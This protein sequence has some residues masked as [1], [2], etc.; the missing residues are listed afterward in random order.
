MTSPPAYLTEYLNKLAKDEGFVEHTLHYE[1]GSNHGDGF[2][3]VM[4]AVTIKGKKTVDADGEDELSLM[5]K[6]LPENRARR[7]FF[8]SYMLFEREVCVY[9]RFLPMFEKFQN[10]RNISR[11]DGFFQYPKCYLAVANAAD[12]HY[13]IVMENVKVSNYEL[14]DK[15]KPVDFD[16]SSIFLQTLGRYHAI[17]IALRDQKPELFKE[18][19][20]LEDILT[21]MVELPNITNMMHGAMDKAIEHLTCEDEKNI[22]RKLRDD[23]KQSIQNLFAPGAAGH[24]GVLLHGDCWNNNFCF[25]TDANN[26]PSE[27]CLFDWQVSCVGSPVLDL[28]YYLL[29]STTKEL[30]VRYTDLIEVYHNSISELLTKLGSDPIK[31]CPIDELNRQLKQFGVYGVIMAPILLQ[32]IVS[33]SKNIVDMDSVTADTDNIDMATMDDKS[34]IVYRDRISDAL[35]DA[36]KFGWI[37]L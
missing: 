2:V 34:K 29:T 3:A 12:D 1:S 4:V 8:N 18:L 9:S 7:E 11:S 37:N 15:M 30:R 21:A 27:I 22:L 13:V 36:I 17:S 6:L 31:L 10:D 28:S 19:L 32:V 33:D 35:Q 5:C 26:K 25:K 24:L 16:T 20:D 14:W 23:Y